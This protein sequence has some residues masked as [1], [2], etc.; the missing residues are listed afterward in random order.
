VPIVYESPSA[1]YRSGPVVAPDATG[2]VAADAVASEAFE[3]A[4][5]TRAPE[6]V[7]AAASNTAALPRMVAEYVRRRTP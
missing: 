1:T 4:G 3:L 2:P 5:D 7:H 6:L